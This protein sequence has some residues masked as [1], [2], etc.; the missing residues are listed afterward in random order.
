MVSSSNTAEVNTPTRFLIAVIDSV[1]NSGSDAELAKITE[2]NRGLQVKGQLVMAAGIAGPKSS[3]QFDFRPGHQEIE[4]QSIYSENEFVS[5]FW[6]IDAQ[7]QAE[8]ESIAKQA[9][10]SCARRVELRPFL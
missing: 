9:S 8:A 3:I 7:N 1:E 5:G 6:I 10:V 2:F 4:T